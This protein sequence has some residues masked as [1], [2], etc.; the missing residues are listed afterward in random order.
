MGLS[1]A[2]VHDDDAGRLTV[3]GAHGGPTAAQDQRNYFGI[4]DTL[5]GDY[6]THATSTRRR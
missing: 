3:Y 4:N 5:V 1:T 2:Q 6:R